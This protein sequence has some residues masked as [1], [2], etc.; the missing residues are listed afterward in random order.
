MALQQ[1]AE[2][3]LLTFSVHGRELQREQR[4]ERQLDRR[5]ID[6]QLNFSAMAKGVVGRAHRGGQRDEALGIELAQQRTRR[7]VLALPVRRHPAPAPAQLLRQT[8]SVP[9]GMGRDQ[10]PDGLDILPR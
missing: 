6:A 3:P 4:R 10:R 1:G 9:G 8:R 7:H 2:Q 5:L